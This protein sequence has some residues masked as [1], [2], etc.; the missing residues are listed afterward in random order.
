MYAGR[1]L[2]ELVKCQY[3]MPNILNKLPLRRRDVAI[4][5]SGA[6]ERPTY[7]LGQWERGGDIGASATHPGPFFYFRWFL[8]RLIYNPALRH[9]DAK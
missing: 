3:I 8:T 2:H 4:I 7:A 1:Q 6:S 9:T 5:K